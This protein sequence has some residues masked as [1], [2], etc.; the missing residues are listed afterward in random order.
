MVSLAGLAAA[1]KLTVIC[2]T[3]MRDY[4]ATD[5]RSVRDKTEIVKQTLHA[6]M[7]WFERRIPIEVLRFVGVFLVVACVSSSWGLSSSMDET[8]LPYLSFV[9]VTL[10][11][12]IFVE[13]CVA[14]WYDQDEFFH[15]QRVL[16]F[17]Y[18]VFLGVPFGTITKIVWLA[19]DS[20]DTDITESNVS[21]P[22]ILLFVILT[23]VVLGYTVFKVQVGCSFANYRT[24]Q[25]TK[26]N[27]DLKLLIFLSLGIGFVT[28]YWVAIAALL[29]Q[30]GLYGDSVSPDWNVWIASLIPVWII[31]G[32]IFVIAGTRFWSLFLRGTVC[33]TFIFS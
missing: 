5:Y 3:G 24:W 22:Y 33:W 9:F 11:V 17:V 7:W 23:V 4:Y 31:V 27:Y 18:S 25:C 32:I 26:R 12:T 28:F 13:W 15:D 10:D 19:Y 1:W 29:R 8:V 20:G 2:C 16:Y 21:V 6:R 14:C 30:T